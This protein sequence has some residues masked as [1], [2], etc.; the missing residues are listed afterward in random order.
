M[1]DSGSFELYDKAVS[2]TAQ[3]VQQ[4]LQPVTITV[5]PQVGPLPML[6]AAIFAPRI[7]AFFNIKAPKYKFTRSHWY[8]AQYKWLDY[9]E[10]NSWCTEHFGEKP[11]YPDAW[12]RWQTVA[13]SG[14][15][16]FRDEEDY[17]LYTLR[18]GNSA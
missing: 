4:K 18:W 6:P 5:Q 16:L 7:P 9:N 15:I 12:S 2:A 17:V 3:W 11:K 13:W 10:V 8:R 14:Q 1:S